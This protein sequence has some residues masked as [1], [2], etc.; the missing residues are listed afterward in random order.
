[1]N[2]KITPLV[3]QLANV[4]SSAAFASY[5]TIGAKNAVAADQAAVTAMRKALSDMPISGTVVIGEGERDKAPMLYIGEQVGAGGVA[6]DIAVDP[7]EGTSLC[8]NNK[9]G[10]VTVIAIAEAGGLL[11]APDCYMEKLAIGPNLPD[12]IVNLNQSLTLNVNNLAQA[13]DK[14]LNQLKICM[15]D[16]PRHQQFFAELNELGIKP[17]LISDGDIL[18]C[19]DVASGSYDMYYGTGGAPEGVLAAAI[20]Q[21]VGGQFYG[22][23]KLDKQQQSHYQSKYGIV[24]VDKQYT[25]AELASK[26]ALV[27]I[28]GVTQ[29]SL[30]NKI[31]A[32]NGK[33]SANSLVF[34]GI[35]KQKLYFNHEQVISA[36][37]M[38]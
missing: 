1:M 16:R 19:A 4:V 36:K 30:V 26:P 28:C 24:D 35:T 37:V 21:V 22:R 9:P 17:M 8:A 12:N 6:V 27:A 18:A 3:P 15:L 14:P 11:K 20:L 25:A 7:L 33:L 5:H 38:A 34:N 23:L 13:V 32:V 2:S 31:E 10:A 29:N